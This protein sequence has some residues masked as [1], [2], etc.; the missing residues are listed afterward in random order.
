[1]SVGTRSFVVVI[2]PTMRTYDRTVPRGGGGRSGEDDAHIARGVEHGKPS[3]S[4]ISRVRE[5]LVS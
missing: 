1:M 2:A 5:Y 3:H 4:Q